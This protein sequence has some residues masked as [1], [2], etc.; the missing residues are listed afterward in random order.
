MKILHVGVF[1]SSS[2]IAGRLSF[3][4]SIL[5]GLMRAVR[6]DVWIIVSN[7][8]TDHSHACPSYTEQFTEGGP[9]RSLPVALIFCSLL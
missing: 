8:R 4:S 5:L 3:R 1:A 6:N 7:L 2:W 9:P